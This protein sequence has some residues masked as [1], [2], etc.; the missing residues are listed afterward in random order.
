MHLSTCTR[1]FFLALTICLTTGSTLYAQNN[2]DC[3]TAQQIADPSNFCSPVFAGDNSFA[4]VSNVP[5]PGCFTGLVEDVWFWFIAEAPNVVIIINGSS[6]T[7]GG[8]LFAPQ[9]ALYEGSCGSLNLLECESD[10]SFLGIIELRFEGLTPGDKY[11][12]R[13]DGQV[14]GTFQFCVRNFFFDGGVSGD[15]PTAIPLCDKRSFNVPAVAGPGTDPSEMDEAPCFLGVGTETNS[16]WYAFTAANNGTLEFR[17]SPNNP[18]DDLDFVVYRLP[19]GM[20]DCTGKIVERC[21]AAGDFVAN[22]PCMGPTGLNATSTSI[23]HGPGCML[24]DDNNFLRFLDVLEGETYALVVNNFTSSGNGFQVDWG[25][26]VEFTG[27]TAIIGTDEPDDLIC[28]GDT[29]RFS[30]LSTSDQGITTDW[31]WTF[32]EGASQNIATTAGPHDIVYQSEGQKIV[33]LNIKSSLG[34]EVSDTRIIQVEDCCPATVS[35]NILSACQD[36]T[37]SAVAEVN[38][39]E[40][41]V[42]YLWS[43]GQQDS[44]ATG[45]PA[46]DY[47]VTITDGNGCMETATF[48]VP[49][50][51]AFT[52]VFPADTVIFTGSTISL[53]VMANNPAVQVTWTG[54]GTP[55]TGNPITVQPAE[56]QTYLV[57]AFIGDCSITDTVQVEVRNVFLEVPNAFTPNNDQLNDTFRPILYAGSLL[58]LS[59]WSRWGE[60]VYEGNSPN[61]WDGTFDG[62]PAPSDVYV[63]NLL[64]RLPDGTEEKRHGDLTL[65]R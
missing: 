23:E 11:F 59:I 6:A 20:G 33:T 57:R 31:G 2:D 7:S 34:C 46:G 64:V 29:I 55:V 47:A 28:L 15:C 37:A 41:P 53:E 43:D 51:V 16:T 63:Y 9:V 5:A 38:G 3:A 61:G 8:S 65:L 39:A 21:M 19:N 62:V 25:G 45:L 18:G 58:N 35:V 32:G 1:S 17:L 42:S 14:P 54:S 40:L 12:F 48:T 49:P 22:S 52:A 26:S 4:T 24:P 44:L 50:P 13:V 60:L 10:V 36:S 27:P 30:D 56:S